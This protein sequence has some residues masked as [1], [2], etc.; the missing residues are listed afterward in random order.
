[1]ETPEKG[2]ISSP[3]RASDIDAVIFDFDGTLRRNE[4][5]GMSYFADAAEQ[6]GLEVDSQTR[7]E[8]A[9]WNHAYWAD[10]DERSA[11]AEAAEG[12]GEGF[13]LNYARRHLRALGATQ[14][15]AEQMAPEI[16]RHMA[17]QYDPVDVVPD[18]VV[19]TLDALRRAGY[20]LALVS[21]RD[22]ALH[23]AVADLALEGKFE[24]ALAAGEVGW[25]KPDPRILL[26][27]AERIGVDPPRAMYVGDN[28]YA[29]VEGA[30]RAG[31]QPVLIDP[32][33]LF[34]EIRCP[35]IR[36]LGQLSA[37][38]ELDPS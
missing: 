30:R 23:Q 28:P 16:H 26:Y 14:R 9:R 33:D 12:D 25:W 32:D 34:P 29:D 13:W 6:Y 5:S 21:N 2:S 1:M 36:R 4:P 10:S 11:D 17:E 35:S 3:L 22:Q 20:Q 7:R 18:D 38:L 37:L 24:L 19:P 31:L 27:A 15:Q 8:A